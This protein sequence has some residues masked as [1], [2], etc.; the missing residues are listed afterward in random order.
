MDVGNVQAWL[1]SQCL[2]HWRC[3]SALIYPV[4]TSCFELWKLTISQVAWKSKR[5]LRLHHGDPAFDVLFRNNL[6][7]ITAQL[8][9]GFH[10]QDLTFTQRITIE[11]I[12]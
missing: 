3:S 2:A 6:I 5:R 10:G 1:H 9:Q 7:H 12:A 4:Y 11:N 8:A